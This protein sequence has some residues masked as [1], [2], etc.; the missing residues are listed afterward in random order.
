MRN[1]WQPLLLVLL[2]V[3]AF[4]TALTAQEPRPRTDALEPGQPET[5]AAPLPGGTSDDANGALS[6]DGRYRITPGDVL[7]LTFPLVPEFDQT[8]TVQPD[9]YI[10]LLNVGDLRVQ[11]RTTRE[12]HAALI[13]AYQAVLLEPRITVVLKEFEKPYFIA[14]GEVAKPGKYELRGAT[15]VTQALAISGGQ[16][17]AG[18]T[19]QVLLFRRYGAAWVEV[20]AVNVKRMYEHH[21]LAEDY[22]LRPG[23]TV[24]VPQTAWSKVVPFLPRPTVGFYINPFSW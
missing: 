11:G 13:D 4:G 20:K 3:S 16:T 8:L 21:D 24:F 5:P 17:R 9:G 19:S 12:L 10:S 22:L 15:T 18:Q 1:R 23:D 7:S 2:A 14:A 6:V